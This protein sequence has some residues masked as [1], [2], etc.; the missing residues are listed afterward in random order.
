[1]GY[2]VRRLREQDGAAAWRLSSVAFGFHGSPMPAEFPAVPGRVTWGVFDGDRLI[3][4]AVDREQG[5]WFG[6]RIVPTSGVAGVA[7]APEVRRGGLGRQV[8]TR[9]LAGARERGAAVSALFPSTPHP[10]RRLGWEEVGALTYLSV[11][12]A[13]LTAVRPSPG[14]SLRPATADDVRAIEALYRDWARSGTGMME[15]SGP[16]YDVA[17]DKLLAAFD[18]VT[19]AVNEAGGVDGYATW[20]RGP[21][22]DPVARI[23]AHGLVAATPEALCAL[24]AMFGGWASVTP[25]TVLRLGPGDPALLEIPTTLVTVDSRQPWMLRLVDAPAAIAARGW[26]GHL[27]G[28]VDL[29]LTDPECPWNAG[30]WRL[31]LDGGLARLEPG[32]SGAVRFTPRGLAAWYAGA[33]TPSVLRR[34]GLLSGDAVADGLLAAATA[35]PVPVLHDFF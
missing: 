14:V 11:P 33:A 18:G 28:I 25:N 4:K 17:P 20:E 35:G 9:L 32:G 1:M 6:G 27:S 12:T 10:Y 21:N 13:A 15:R 19:V 5:Q 16:L 24:L 31:V 22:S 2:E 30:S 29:A 3:A 34:A 7:V 26:P 23:T 8:L